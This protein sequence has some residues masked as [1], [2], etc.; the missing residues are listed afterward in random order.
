[1]GKRDAHSPVDRR[2]SL[3]LLALCNSDVTKSWLFLAKGNSTRVVRRLL[4][5]AGVPDIRFRELRHTTATLLLSQGVHPK[6]VQERLG[7]SQF[8]VTLDTYSHVL[9]TMQIEAAAKF[10]EM[11]KATPMSE[12]VVCGKASASVA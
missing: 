11:L 3:S 6:V 7:H 12:P 9:P 2:R 10:D 4:E 8:S 1:M 5:R